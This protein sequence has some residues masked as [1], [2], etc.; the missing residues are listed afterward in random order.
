M[1]IVDMGSSFA[2]LEIESQSARRPGQQKPKSPPEAIASD[3]P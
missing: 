3:G 1:S 2:Y